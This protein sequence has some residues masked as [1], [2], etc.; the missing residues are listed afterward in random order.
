MAS[1]SLALERA[2]VQE[3]L[4]FLSLDAPLHLPPT[5]RETRAASLEAFPA[6]VRRLGGDP[7]EIL[8]R[9]GIEASLLD[10][11]D[12]LVACGPIAGSLEYCSDLFNNRSFGLLLGSLQSSSVFG[13]IA[14]LCRTAP[15]FGSALRCFADYMPV[16]NSPGCEF[17]ILDGSDIV[18]LRMRWKLR[19]YVDAYGQANYMALTRITSF[20][21]ELSRHAVTPR[22]VSMPDNPSARQIAEMEEIFGCRVFAKGSLDVIGFAPATMSQPLPTSN[23]LVHQLLTLY[24]Q[25]AKRSSEASLVEKI[26]QYVTASI[27]SGECNIENCCRAIGISLRKMQVDL[28]RE[29]LSFSDI[30]DRLRTRLAKR[31]IEQ[32]DM[33]LDEVAFLLGY[34]EQT[35]F[36]RAFKRWTGDTP[37]HFQKQAQREAA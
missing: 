15:D 16:I 17:E 37:R 32:E 22:Y 33:S 5:V 29:G 8:D 35:S 11:P 10:D 6:L 28:K 12:N 23:R 36:G 13:C 2:E 18:E 9:N 19:D 27:A 24:I 1:V 20:F 31:Y 34:S 7:V 21:K 3:N 30:M 25:N 4:D 14:S 26:E